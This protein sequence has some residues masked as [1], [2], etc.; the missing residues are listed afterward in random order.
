MAVQPSQKINQLNDIEN[1]IKIYRF[2]NILF[3]II[4]FIN[5]IITLLKSR[6]LR[7]GKPLIFQKEFSKN[8]FP[9]CKIGIFEI[10]NESIINMI[11]IDKKQLNN[12]YKIKESQIKK[13]KI[14][15]NDNNAI[16]I[17]YIIIIL[18]KFIYIFCQIKSKKLLDL[19]HY[20]NSKITLKIK[21]IGIYTILGNV[22]N[23]NFKSINYL[24]EVY[25]NGNRQDKIE[26]KYNCNQTNNFIELIWDD[27][28]ND[29]ENKFLINRT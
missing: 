7:R 27:N 29:C 22:T 9:F 28:I 23:G 3:S 19:F 14:N 26:Y 18:I 2:D 21:G 20:Q 1:K 11:L 10:K 25:I 6:I 8:V 13:R 15:I 5:R 17:N 12:N 16:I 24:N 4:I